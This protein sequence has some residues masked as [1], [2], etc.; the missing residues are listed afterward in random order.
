MLVGLADRDWISTLWEVRVIYEVIYVL[1][2]WYNAMPTDLE[3]Y[4]YSFI[5]NMYNLDLYNISLKDK[6]ITSV[7]ILRIFKKC[8][9]FYN[10]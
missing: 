9:S 1:I 2:Q 7:F 5:W 8:I 6:I 10:R 4:N 3:P